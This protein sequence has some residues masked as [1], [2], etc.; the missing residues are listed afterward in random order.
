MG[1]LPMKLCRNEPNNPCFINQFRSSLLSAATKA[2]ARYEAHLKGQLYRAMTNWS[3]S[4]GSAEAK[5]CRRISTLILVRGP[6]LG[7]FAKQSQ[8]VLWFHRRGGRHV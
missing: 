4:N 1:R 3:V 7:F 8:E 5:T 6:R 2:V